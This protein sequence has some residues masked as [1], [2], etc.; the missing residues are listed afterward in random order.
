MKVWDRMMLAW[1]ALL[2]G[3]EDV[4]GQNAVREA[5]AEVARRWGTAAGRDPELAGD[6]I[7]LSGLLTTDPLSFD[8][9]TGLAQP[10][11]PYREFELKGRREF[12]LELL[13]F[14]QMSSDEI[15]QLMESSE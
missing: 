15:S 4:E 2:H 12:A 8:V 11:D 5:T 13:A 6:V 7:R 1:A 9:E 10:R 14:M 3:D